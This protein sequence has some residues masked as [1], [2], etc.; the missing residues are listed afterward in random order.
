[1]AANGEKHKRS[2]AMDHIIHAQM[3]GET[4]VENVLYIAENIN[5]AGIET[6]LWS[7]ERAIAELVNHPT[8]QKKIRDEI[9]TVLKG[10]PVTESHLH[11]LPY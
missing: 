5:V 3:K 7:M 11:E 4:S 9:T 2:C 8:V 10:N 1:M 6:A